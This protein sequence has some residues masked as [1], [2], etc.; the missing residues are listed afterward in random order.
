MRRWLRGW[1]GDRGERAARRYLRGLGYAILARDWRS[2]LGQ[3]DLV[4]LDGDVVVFVEVKTR[5]GTEAGHPAESIT[6]QKQ[7][8]LTRLAL[9]FLKR[10]RLLE[11]SARFDVLAVHWPPGARRPSIEHIRNAFECTGDFGMYG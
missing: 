2:R 6:P 7:R 5:S 8:Q 3:I 11:K 10:H 4:A 9:Q 1:L